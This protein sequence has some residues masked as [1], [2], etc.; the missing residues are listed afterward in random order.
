[1]P[2]EKNSG[3]NPKRFLL[4]KDGTVWALMMAIATN[5]NVLCRKELTL[6]KE[7]SGLCPPLLKLV[8][9]PLECP[10]WLK[11]L[12]SPGGPWATHVSLMTWFMART[13]A[14]AVS[15]LPPE[16]LEIKDSFVG[17]L[18]EQVPTKT[19]DAKTWVSFPERQHPGPTAACCCWEKCVLSRTA[20]GQEIWRSYTRNLATLFPC[21]S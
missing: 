11:H 13:L 2:E 15:G 6:S 8:S 14:Q 18:C 21:T 19:P 7:R 10:A 20:L 12:C 3:T 9:R 5:W 16:G 1:M 4:V 17:G